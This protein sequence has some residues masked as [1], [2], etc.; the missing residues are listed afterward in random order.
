MRRERG[1]LA[2]RRDQRDAGARC[3]GVEERGDVALHRGD[4]GSGGGQGGD[5]VEQTGGPDRR[6]RVGIEQHRVD[7]AGGVAVISLLSTSSTFGC[8]IFRSS[9]VKVDRT[10]SF[11]GPRVIEVSANDRTGIG[12]PSPINDALIFGEARRPVPFGG[13]PDRSSVNACAA[14]CP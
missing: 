7:G 2:D 10:P 9:S 4:A 6:R 5:T 13:G 12:C 3:H 8:D 11:F 14:S 1:G